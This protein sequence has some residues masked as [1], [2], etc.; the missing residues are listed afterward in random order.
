MSPYIFVAATLLAA[1]PI[2]LIFKISIERIK[3]NPEAVMKVQTQFFIWVALAEVIPLLLIIYGMMNLQS[4]NGIEALYVP[5][6]IIFLTIGFATLFIIL[7]RFF[8]VTE[9]SKNLIQ[10]FSFLG[11][12]MANAIPFVCIIGLF[13][14][15]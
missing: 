12:A 10:T 6:I 11:I 4:G 2:L 15:I 9:E 1:L 8:D 13:M 14:M 3:E 7:Q 5:A